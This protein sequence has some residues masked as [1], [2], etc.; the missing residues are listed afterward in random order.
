MK[1]AIHILVVLLALAAVGCSSGKQSWEKG[2]YYGA[3]L[4]AIDRLKK[5]PD[6]KKSSEVLRQAYPMAVEKLESDIIHLNT[7]QGA[8]R[9]R[10]VVDRY[11][12]LNTLYDAIRHTPGALA[13]IPNPRHYHAQLRDARD[14]AA[15]E[16]Y[17]AGQLELNK[18]TREAA[19]LAYDHFR[20]THYYVPNYRDSEQKMA[21][22][23][24][25]ATLK[26]L[27]DQIPVPG[28]YA[29]DANY[30]QD[31]VEAF[32]HNTRPQH[33]FVRF[34]SQ[35]EAEAEQLKQPDHYVRIQF[36]EFI[37]GE[38]HTSELREQLK[39]DSV[40]I[41]TVKIKG[42]SVVP[43]YGTVEAKLTKFR[44]EIISRG[45]VS[46]YIVDA[47]TNAVL[48]HRQF[49][50]EFVWFSE[51]GYFNGDE[52]ALEPK[53]RKI[54]EQRDVPPPPPQEMFH[55]FAAPIFNQLTVACR[56]FYGQYN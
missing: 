7:L 43:V 28:R 37:I 47:R 49:P 9:W 39:R 46:M 29:F 44:K 33:Q 45:R 56:Q 19:R 32:L 2:N 41:G 10:G 42:D 34:Y 52:R 13:I 22:A 25:L 53:H 17:A 31:Q 12:Q 50:G 27:V 5:N 35:P 11:E 23:L 38:T 1:Q 24:Y 36:D 26:V 14:M 20:A 54:V 51:W 48:Q 55:N 18:G 21:E 15:A 8:N 40:Q 6:H 16:S 4:Q 30:F 3:T